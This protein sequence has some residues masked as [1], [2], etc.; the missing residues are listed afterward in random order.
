D[1]VLDRQPKQEGVIQTMGGITV[2][3]DT[4]LDSGLIQEGQARE[5]V[6]RIQKLRKDLNF[7]VVDR[8]Q[9]TFETSPD[10][11][12]AFEAHRAYIVAETLAEQFE[13]KFQSQWTSEQDIDG[14]PLKLH[15]QKA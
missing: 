12:T 15:I 1:V 2:W 3:L 5:L 14:I 6:N 13:P 9:V 8:I 10:L 11:K 7:E 4:K